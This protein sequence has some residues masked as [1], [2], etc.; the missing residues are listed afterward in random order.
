M[1][2]L[3]VR[4]QRHHLIF[5]GKGRHEYISCVEFSHSEALAEVFISFIIIF[6]VRGG[7]GDVLFCPWPSYIFVLFAFV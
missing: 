2:H 4:C 7:G 6:G 1:L 3:R 5:R